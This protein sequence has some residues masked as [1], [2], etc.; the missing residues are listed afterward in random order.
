MPARTVTTNN[1]LPPASSSSSPSFVASRPL[2]RSP[3]LPTFTYQYNRSNTFP[4]YQI[5]QYVAAR[6][7][8]LPANHVQILQQPS[9]ALARVLEGSSA[10][11]LARIS[12]GHQLHSHGRSTPRRLQTSPSSSSN[13][14]LAEA[15][16]VKEHGL[17]LTDASYLVAYLRATKKS[18]STSALHGMSIADARTKATNAK[19]YF[20]TRPMPKMTPTIGT[21]VDTTYNAPS[22]TLPPP[23]KRAKR[24]PKKTAT[25]SPAS[26]PLPQPT[27]DEDL[28]SFEDLRIADSPSTPKSSKKKMPAKKAAPKTPTKRKTPAKTH[29]SLHSQMSRHFCFPHHIL[30]L[31][32]MQRGRC[33]LFEVAANATLRHG[34][35]MPWH[36]PRSAPSPFPLRCIQWHIC[37]ARITS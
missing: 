33:V 31:P 22:T 29:S 3:S 24:M 14:Q 21:S 11:P 19:R 13:P 20:E 9:R 16:L 15:L 10:A 34:I 7:P 23:P 32:I 26:F 1:Q 4:T 36:L 30:L 28:E 5:A 27:A 35:S 12:S 25:H 37:H 17:S 8:S 6:P 18:I 2:P